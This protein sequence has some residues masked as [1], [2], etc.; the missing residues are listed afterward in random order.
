MSFVLRIGEK[1]ERYYRSQND[2]WFH[3][4]TDLPP[5]T[6]TVCG[7]AILTYEPTLGSAYADYKDG[8]YEESNAT[9]VSDGVQLNNGY[10][11][12]A[13]RSPY[14]IY[15]SEITVNGSGLT[16]QVSYD[17]GKTWVNYSSATQA[18]QRYDYLLKVVAHNTKDLEHFLVNRLTPIPGVARIH[19]SLVLREVKS[20]TAIPVKNAK[21]R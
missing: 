13:I 5:N 19:T 8:I 1:M 15:S 14:V 11:T 20:S 7:H 10:V 2:S 16:K 18:S 3:P 21:S 9:L 6:P 12:W 17:L 4:R